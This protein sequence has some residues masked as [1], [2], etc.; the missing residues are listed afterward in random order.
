MPSNSNLKVFTEI[1]SL[2]TGFSETELKATGMVDCYY[3]TIVSNNN[4][5]DVEFFF[6]NARDILKDP[7][8]TE[9]STEQ[10]IATQLIPDSCYSG[11]AKN[12]ITLWYLGT[13]NNN[14]VSADA[15]IQGLIWTAGHTHPPAA[16]QPGYGSWAIPPFSV[17]EN[18]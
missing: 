6:K 8:R 12:L 18:K 13:W 2:L 4:P 7:A 16:K 17:N 9:Q 15:Y 3:N 1:S 5:V 14:V 10:A 11:L